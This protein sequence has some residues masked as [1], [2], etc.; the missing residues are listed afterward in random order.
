METK[1]VLFDLDGTLLP[2]D[3]ERFT[4]TYFQLLAAKLA[5]LGYDPA[6]LVD[7]IWAGTAAMVKN[8]GSC[9]NEEAFWRVF[10]QIYGEASLKD[11]PYIDTFYAEEFNQAKA[12][13]GFA[14][15]AA[16]TVD[17]LRTAGKTVVLATNPIFPA[18][19]TQNRIRWAGIDAEDFEV[20]TTYETYHYCK[21]NPKY[22]QEVMEEFGLNPKECLMVGNDVQEDLTIRSLGVK[23]YLLTDTLEN[24]K[25][26]PLEEVETEYKGTMEELYEWFQSYF[27]HN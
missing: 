7:S 12:A 22:F 9:T 19:A 27:V 14:P 4:K 20:I 18:V 13:C 15:A 21:P 26:I 3:Q 16:E 23:T 6:K 17:L 10:S 24:K 2:M 25:N 5:P 8:D 11:K 1:A